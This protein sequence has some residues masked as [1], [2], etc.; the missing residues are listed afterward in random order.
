[1]AS[2][3]V[4]KRRKESGLRADSAESQ[5]NGSFHVAVEI[6]GQNPAKFVPRIPA[7]PQIVP[8]GTI[9]SPSTILNTRRKCETRVTS[10][11]QLFHVEQ[12]DAPRRAREL[13]VIWLGEEEDLVGAWREGGGG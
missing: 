7:G 6:S 12:F 5:Y 9:S 1:M 3:I 10:G 4:R 8:R 2:Q 13:V 11:R